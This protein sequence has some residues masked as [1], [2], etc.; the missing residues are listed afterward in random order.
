MPTEQSA[1]DTGSDSTTL[2]KLAAIRMRIAQIRGTVMQL[3]FNSGYIHLA[4]SCLQLALIYCTSVLEEKIIDTG[5][6]ISILFKEPAGLF[7]VTE[8][9]EETALTRLRNLIHDVSQDFEHFMELHPAVSID[10][11]NN[12]IFV[13][14]EL[15]SASLWMGERTKELKPKKPGHA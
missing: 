15:V 10:E 3:P 11:K 9:T 7:T 8:V 6:D 2:L 1:P 4:Q 12:H 5:R 14:T 13:I